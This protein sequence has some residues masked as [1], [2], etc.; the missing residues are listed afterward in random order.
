MF[1]IG[2]IENYKNKHKVK[3]KW[4]Q[5]IFSLYITFQ[6]NVTDN[7]IISITLEKWNNDSE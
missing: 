2:K 4:V 6:L 5:S 3:S 7:I 1:I